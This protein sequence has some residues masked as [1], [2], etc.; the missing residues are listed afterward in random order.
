M[1]TWA[2]LVCDWI[3]WLRVRV[4]RVCRTSSIQCSVARKA[5]CRASKL[6]QLKTG[7]VLMS[8]RGGLR[9][10]L[11]ARLRSPSVNAMLIVFSVP[12]VSSKE[13][14]QGTCLIRA[15]TANH[16]RLWDRYSVC[17]VLAVTVSLSRSKVQGFLIKSRSWM[18]MVI[19]QSPNCS[20]SSTNLAGSSRR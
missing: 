19:G 18:K 7:C 20:L 13:S 12:L 4:F 16:N 10:F 2:V 15:P 1:S 3:N 9:R 6:L 17:K 8:S 14:H 11:R 5:S